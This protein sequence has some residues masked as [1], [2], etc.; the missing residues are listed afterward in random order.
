MADGK[1]ILHQILSKL[2]QQGS[3]IKAL[4]EEIAQ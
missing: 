1:D 2:D 3:D 4:R